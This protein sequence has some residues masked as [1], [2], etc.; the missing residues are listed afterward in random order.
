M[1]GYPIDGTMGRSGGGRVRMLADVYLH[2]NAIVARG[3]LV[4]NIALWDTRTASG[5]SILLVLLEPHYPSQSL[6]FEQVWHMPEW[7]GGLIYNS[8]CLSSG[9]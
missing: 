4:T 3:I 6:K 9:S 7:I 5:P 2:Y 1:T 8:V